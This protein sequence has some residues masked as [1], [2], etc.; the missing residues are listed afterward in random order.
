MWQTFVLRPLDS[1]QITSISLPAP[2]PGHGKLLHTNTAWPAAGSPR[3]MLAQCLFGFAFLFV[4]PPL[5]TT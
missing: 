4:I 1:L 2:G 3:G 5:L